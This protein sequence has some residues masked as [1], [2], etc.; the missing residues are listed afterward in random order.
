MRSRGEILKDID[1]YPDEFFK[2]KV[3]KIDNTTA[4]L[5]ILLDIRDLLIP[6]VGA[7]SQ[8]EAGLGLACQHD[9]RIKEHQKRTCSKCGM[10]M[11]FN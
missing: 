1:G 7:V 6:K 10:S 11:S 4:V 8:S 3:P 2:V 5:E 9:W